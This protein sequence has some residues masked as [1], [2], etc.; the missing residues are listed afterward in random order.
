MLLVNETKVLYT[1][2]LPFFARKILT[3]VAA[4]KKE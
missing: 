2:I 1:R 3:N 4:D